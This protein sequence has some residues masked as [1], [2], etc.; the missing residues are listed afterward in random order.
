MATDNVEL[1][2]ELYESFG[3]GDIPAV[4]SA[5]ADDI[6]WNA[7]DVLPHGGTT[8]GKDGVAA[9]FGRLASTWED[10]DLTI[11]AVFGSGER[12]CAVG[13][14]GGKLDGVQTG[15]GCAHVWTVADGVLTRFD[16]YVDPSPEM[17][18]G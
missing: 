16:E 13:R 9:F 10:F 11:D 5:F 15:Y 1:V 7:P 6:E 4:L 3:R 2:G 12:V 8:R 17:L 18:A 14:G